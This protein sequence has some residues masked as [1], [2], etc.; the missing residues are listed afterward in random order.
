MDSTRVCVMDQGIV[1]E[2]DTPYNLLHKE[3]G[4][5][6]GMVLAAN[7]PTLFDM[8]E[9][10]EDVK[11]ELKEIEDQKNQT[12]VSPVE[13]SPLEKSD[14]ETDT[15]LQQMIRKQF[16]NCTTLTIAHR[17]N[18]IMDSTRVCVMDQG[19]VA[20]FDT[21]YNLL[22]KEGGMFKGMILAANDPTLFDMVS[23]CEEMK[24]E[25]KE[26][27]DQNNQT[28]VSP[29]DESISTCNDNEC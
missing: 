27:E 2:F 18:T 23:G 22:H 12:E 13:E 5:F 20:E 24:A 8:V 3:G 19:V 17:L 14:N 9:N 1:A 28:E 11:A 25:L 16:A 4:I 6:K 26:I 21:P 15:F 10:C 29:V 7:D